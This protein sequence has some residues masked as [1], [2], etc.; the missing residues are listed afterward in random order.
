MLS[1]GSQEQRH[2]WAVSPPQ[3]EENIPN[4]NKT[5]S[6]NKIFLFTDARNFFSSYNGP[7]LT[8]SWNSQPS[9]FHEWKRRASTSLIFSLAGSI[10][11]SFL[12]WIYL[13]HETFIHSY[14]PNYSHSGA[15]HSRSKER[16]ASFG[17]LHLLMASLPSEIYPIHYQQPLCAQLTM[18][19]NVI[20]LLKMLRSPKFST[21]LFGK[22]FL[23]KVFGKLFSYVCWRVDG[24]RPWRRSL[25]N[26]SAHLQNESFAFLRPLPS[27][28]KKSWLR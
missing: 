23:K 21:K 15:S 25:Q 27:C 26:L 12:I 18:S 6:G 5:S 3:R 19:G 17:N 11:H 2:S 9:K 14:S 28:K 22:T 4:N 13:Q 20:V 7:A 1:W 16:K 8:F 24:S 10:S